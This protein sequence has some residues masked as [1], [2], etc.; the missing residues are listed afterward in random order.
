MTSTDVEKHES[1]PSEMVWVREPSEAPS[2]RFGWSGENLGLF[3]VAG[4]ISAIVLLCML[5]GNHHGKVE[6]IYLIAIAAVILLLIAAD[7]IRRRGKYKN[8][9]N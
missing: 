4:V 6:D 5:V 3:R 8:Y 1:L 7:L 9:G 2:A